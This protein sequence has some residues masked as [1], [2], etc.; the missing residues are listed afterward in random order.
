MSRIGATF[1]RLS[2]REKLL[3]GGL[4]GTLVLFGAFFFFLSY[5]RSINT[6]EESV[7]DGQEKLAKIRQ[8]SAGYLEKLEAL[9]RVKEKAA[10][11]TGVDLQAII[12]RAARSLSFESRTYRGEAGPAKILS[13]A[14]MRMSAPK[15]TWLSKRKRRSG[16]QVEKHGYWRRDQEVTW[17]EKVAFK[18]LYEFMAKVEKNDEMRYIKKVNLVRDRYDADYAQSGASILVSSIYYRAKEE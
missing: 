10:A 1:S 13:D 5:S 17:R 15:E 4:I 14:K 2:R 3:V 6:L 7:L 8:S 18:V 11:N 9:E 12:N 16:K